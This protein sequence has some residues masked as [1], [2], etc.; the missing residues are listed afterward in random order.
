MA[1]TVDRQ[2][3]SWIMAQVRSCDTKPERLVRAALRNLRI[4]I[5]AVP[6]KLPGNP[7]FVIPA[8]RLAVFVNG[9]FWHWHGCPRSRMPADNRVYWERKIARNVRRDR[10]VKRLLSNA[11]WHYWTIWECSLAAG[12]ARLAGKIKTLAGTRVQR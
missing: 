3:R 9:C 12:I 11:G 1:D 4:R 6:K 10:R 7:D 2:T 8:I 5:G